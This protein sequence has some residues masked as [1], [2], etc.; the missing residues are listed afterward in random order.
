M[1]LDYT[2]IPG[3]NVWRPN[4]YARL[5]NRVANRQTLAVPMLVD[6]GSDR[7]L[8]DARLAHQIGINP[9]AGGI[10]S[11]TSGIGGRV[12]TAVWSI[13][14]EFPQLR[15]VIEIQAEFTNGLPRGVNGLLGNLGF[16]DRFSKICFL[17]QQRRFSIEV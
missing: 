2:I 11:E 17:P 8:L 4:L 13:E 15:R 16:L 9:I 1:I 14:V 5:W 6:T 12:A 7:C 10:V 3:I